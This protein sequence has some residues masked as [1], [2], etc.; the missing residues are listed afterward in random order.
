VLVV[1]AVAVLGFGGAVVALADD[2][3]AGCVTTSPEDPAYQAQLLGPMRSQEAE[4]EVEITRDGRPVVGAKVCTKVYMVGMEAMGSSD[5]KAVEV[6]P[7]VYRLTIVFPMGG[8]WQ[9]A[10]LVTQRGQARI[11]VPLRFDVV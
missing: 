1:A 9:G 10:L 11:S 3:R 8:A 5:G 6:S 4:H 7:G 2:A